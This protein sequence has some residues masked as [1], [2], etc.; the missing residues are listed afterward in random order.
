MK[1]PYTKPLL[2]MEMFSMSQMAARDCA[3][4]IPT[5]RLTFADG[6]NCGW[7]VN[8]TII[9]IDGVCEVNGEESNFACYNNPSE[10][11][12]IFRS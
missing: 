9:F 11:N 2:T 5:D 6:Q 8:G 12:Y 10:G 3:D 4:F 1:S 7:D